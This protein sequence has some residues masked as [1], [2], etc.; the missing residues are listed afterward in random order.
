MMGFLFS[1]MLIQGAKQPVV[2]SAPEAV[3]GVELT[4]YHQNFALVKEKRKIEL[5]KGLNLVAVEGVAAHID[6][7]SVHFK[8]LTAPEQVAVRE[9]NYFYDLL[10]PNSVLTK[11]LGRTI[12]VRRLLETGQL[13]E[14]RGT[15]LSTPENGIILRTQEGKLVLNPAGEVQVEEVPPDLVSR[16]TLFWKLES[17]RAGTHECEITYLTQNVNWHVEYVA[18]INK[19]DTKTDLTGWVTL[20]NR[21][22][23]AYKEARLKLVAGDVRRV[24]PPPLYDKAE[25]ARAAPGAPQFAEKEFFEYH[26]Y[27]LQGTTTLRHHEIKQ[28]TL[29]EATNVGVRKRLIYEAT[30][31]VWRYYS[32]RPGEA[33]ASAPPSKLNIVLEVA[34]TEANRMGIPL[35]KGKIRFYKADEEG[36]LQFIGED[37]IDHTPRNEKLRLYLGDAFDVVGERKQIEYKR[38]ATNM[39]E[40]SLEIR[41]RNRKKEAVEVT[42]VEHPY[43]DWQILSASHEWTK[44]DAQTIEFTH[45]LKPDEEWVVTYRVRYR[46]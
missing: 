17:D 23:T 35:P 33:F 10:S 22:G 3:H 27:T 30:R 29:L 20:E 12:T 18:V 4:V 38:I 41:V 21:S 32:H 5:R 43:G 34:N 16:P 19:E 44:V 37:E 15:L 46:Y 42:I 1:L 14:V 28:M 11:S 2:R 8:S 40:E 24:Q 6:P 9:Q 26:L 25:L 36:Q 13:H 31:G 39:W 7:T 45:T